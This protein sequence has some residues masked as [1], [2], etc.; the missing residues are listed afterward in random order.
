MGREK[1]ANF[2]L[3]GE[4]S[5][6]HWNNAHKSQLFDVTEWEKKGPRASVKIYGYDTYT[7]S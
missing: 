4:A 6:L 5:T 7:I 1:N 3:G 2:P